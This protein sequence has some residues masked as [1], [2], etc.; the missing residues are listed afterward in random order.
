MS[1][2]R[3]TSDARGKVGKRKKEYKD[4]FSPDGKDYYKAKT[5]RNAYVTVTAGGSTLPLSENTYDSAYANPSGKPGAIL[6]SVKVKESGDFGLLRQV[7]VQFTCFRRSTFTALEKAFL[8]PDQKLTVKGGYVDGSDSFTLSDYTIFK[9]GFSLNAQNHYVCTFT[10]YGPA[11]F[12]G[13]FNIKGSVPASW[14]N[15]KF[16]APGWDGEQTV[17]TFPQYLKYKAQGNGSSANVDITNGTIQDGAIL[18]LDNPTSM[19]P[20]GMFMKKV[21]K[22]LQSLGMFGADASK[23]VYCTLEWFVKQINTHYMSQ[24]TSDISD[25]RYVCD[26]TVTKGAYL[27]PICSSI[28][29]SIIITGANA[30]NY[31]NVTGVEEDERLMADI[32]ATFGHVAP[33]GDYSKVLLSYTYLANKVFGALIEEG[34]STDASNSSGDSQSTPKVAIQDIFDTIFD[35][36]AQA[37]GGA[38]LLATM[39]NPSNSKQILIVCKNSNDSVEETLFDPIHGD[40]ISREVIVTCDVPSNDA[41]A[42]ANGAA[43]GASGNTPDDIA[44]KD[45]QGENKAK[46]SAAKSTITE[47]RQTNLAKGGF[48]STDSDALAENLATYVETV[49][50]AT[51]IKNLPADKFTWPLKLQIKIDGI[52]GFRFGD[53][54]STT[55]LPARYRKQ[56]IAVG[57]I[58]L[59]YTHTFADN[60]WETEL[61]SQCTLLNKG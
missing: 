31:G 15:L 19:T 11:P 52:S 53:A 26:S 6:N 44:G 36:I 50:K 54:I 60:D 18:I 55:F 4:S 46:N 35:D 20:E 39:E 7:D 17:S 47:Y 59:S 43:G 34:K 32:H 42:V 33:G 21:Y 30:G 22:V 10:A 9:Y 2:F 25:I 49:G 61:V 29:M 57:F 27:S 51:A 1:Q 48:D 16:K 38:V 40:G 45:K 24:L 8:V 28:P 58:V 13:E 56:G 3:H 23:L 14:S 5:R 37:T 12:V 41:Y